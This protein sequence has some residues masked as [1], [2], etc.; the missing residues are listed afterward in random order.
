M[1]VRYNLLNNCCSF[2]SFLSILLLLLLDDYKI[3]YIFFCKYLFCNLKIKIINFNVLC[4]IE[5]FVYD[6]DYLS[7]SYKV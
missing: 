2:L 4:V 1:S 7:F 6:C 3:L 5:I